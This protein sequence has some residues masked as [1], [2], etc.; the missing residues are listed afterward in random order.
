M[1]VLLV[2][3]MFVCALFS[4]ASGGESTD[5]GAGQNLPEKI[6]SDK[7]SSDK[8]SSDKI[9]KRIKELTAEFYPK[10][11]IKSK[12][13]N[14]HIE[15]KTRPFEVPASG[16]VEPGPEWGGILVD[17][18]LKDGPYQGKD[19]VPKK[20]NEYSFY[21]VVLM[22]PYSKSHD[23]HLLTRVAY[24]FDKSAEYVRQLGEIV[25]DLD[26]YL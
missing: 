3:I 2:S 4:P 1:R 18:E 11:K 22:A 19:A 6:S 26:S 5:S 10:A 8:I 16:A 14:L 21:H 24:P 25:D 13:D 7:I 9:F 23:C 17:V 15:F 12:G 20:F